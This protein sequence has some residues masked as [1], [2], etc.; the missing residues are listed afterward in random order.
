MYLKRASKLLDLTVSRTTADVHLRDLT[1]PICRGILIEPVTLPCTH[2]L[3]LRCLQGTFEHNS[4]SCPLC[5]VR[6]GSWVRTATRS[7]TL[8]NHGLW[9]LIR[10]K[11]PKEVE[12][13]HNGEEGDL[14][15]LD[16]G[17]WTRMYMRAYTYTPA[18]A[19]Y[20]RTPSCSPAINKCNIT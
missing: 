10:S 2:N 16:A 13:K 4:L 7:E 1:C 9:E 3:C 12:S 17:E 19:R 8:V 6:V 15:G 14:A 18:R 5:R 11:F 20:A